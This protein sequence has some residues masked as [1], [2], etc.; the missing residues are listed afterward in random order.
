M[1]IEDSL[2]RIAAALE[3]IAVMRTTPADPPVGAPAETASPPSGW[4][5]GESLKAGDIVTIQSLPPAR[6]GRPTKVAP[7]TE[8]APTAV[9]GATP[10]TEANPATTSPSVQSAPATMT[11]PRSVKETTEA[12]LDLANNHSR[13]YAVAILKKYGANKCSELKA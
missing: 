12:I 10:A 13:E 7:Q 2:S 5:S 3:H 9:V 8:T 6:R 11:A 4:A 1:S